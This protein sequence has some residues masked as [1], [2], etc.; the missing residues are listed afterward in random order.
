MLPMNLVV[1]QR[2]ARF[3]GDAVCNH[4]STVSVVRPTILYSPSIPRQTMVIVV[5][6]AMVTVVAMRMTT[7]SI[8]ILL[9]YIFVML[10]TVLR[11][12]ISID[13]RVVSQT[14]GYTIMFLSE[15]RCI[16]FEILK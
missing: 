13:R 5:R 16:N 6:L 3:M 10:V 11:R 1:V 2:L 14:I 12:S 9:I 4:P 15:Q 8:T 7:I